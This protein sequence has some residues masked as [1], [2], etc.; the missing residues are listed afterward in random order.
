MK[1][2]HVIVN[3]PGEDSTTREY[4]F[5]RAS[6]FI[7]GR[8]PDCD[9]RIPPE[10]LFE[11]VSRHHC[12]LDIDPPLIRLRDLGSRNGTYLNGVLIGHRPKK[13]PVG[14]TREYE[15]K[16]YELHD[17]DEVQV[18]YVTIRVE[19]EEVKEDAPLTTVVPMLFV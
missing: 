14:E 8:A 1:A 9:I 13:L 19:I 3:M 15:G 6:H 10:S 7:V 16:E 11:D 17:Q 5:T 4:M 12:E 18:G 2:V